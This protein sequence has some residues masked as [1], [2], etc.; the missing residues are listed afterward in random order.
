MSKINKSS[1]YLVLLLLS[2]LPYNTNILFLNKYTSFVNYIIYLI[3]FILIIYV[4]MYIK[5]NKLSTNEFKTLKTISWY[6]ALVFLINIFSSTINSDI[7]LFIIFQRSFSIIYIYAFYLYFIFNFKNLTKFLKI[8]MVVTLFLLIFSFVLY[9]F[10]PNIGM[11]YEGWNSYAFLGVANNR[12]N[13]YELFF[14]LIVILN[15]LYPNVKNKYIIISILAIVAIVLSKSVT[16]IISTIIYFIIVFSCKIFK[17]NYK[18]IKIALIIIFIIWLLFFI[19]LFCNINI[20]AISLSFENKSST[21]SGRTLIWN[22]A[23]HFIKENPLIGYGYDNEIIGNSKNYS[24]LFNQVFP[25]DTHNSILYLLLTSGITGLFIYT[26][27][28]VNAITRGLKSIKIDSRY[29]FLFAYLISNLIRGITE[30]CLHYT[31]LFIFLTIIIMLNGF[32]D[33]KKEEKYEKN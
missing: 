17:N 6:F 5:N 16:S 13:I 29:T 9:I 23:L 2:I 8:F 21:F 22:K 15:F 28:L 24:L 3:R 31:H 14:P 10:F 32:C 30:S 27:L 4:L 7:D 19:T 33:K 12:N 11:I 26:Y 1:I 18:I 25:N 20:S